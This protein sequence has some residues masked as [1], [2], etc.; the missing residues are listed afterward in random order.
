[1]GSGTGSLCGKSYNGGHYCQKCKFEGLETNDSAEVLGRKWL[2][3]IL[4]PA[5]VLKRPRLANNALRGG[6]PEAAVPT[7]R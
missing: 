1:M 5:H 7:P 6:E 4:N 2:P 3:P